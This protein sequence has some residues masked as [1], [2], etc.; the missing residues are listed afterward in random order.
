MFKDLKVEEKP[1]PKK[2]QNKIL[3][4]FG[5]S[6]DNA[7]SFEIS[8]AS[9]FKLMCCT[10]DKS[11]KEDEIL[12]NIQNQLKEVQQKLNLIERNQYDPQPTEPRKSK[13]PTTIHI[14]GNY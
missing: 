7:G 8:F 4:F 10:Y 9:L 5:N 14:E 13:R 6:N 11:G 1:A 2:E 3:S 12:R